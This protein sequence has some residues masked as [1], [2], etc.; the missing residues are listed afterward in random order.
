M[1]D[2]LPA[3]ARLYPPDRL[4]TRAAS[5]ASYESDGLTAFRTRPLAVV[6]AESNHDV[7]ETVRLC[8]AAGVPFVARGSG[9]SLSGGSVPIAD[10]VV[11][12]LNRMNRVLRLDPVD[13]VAVVQPGVINL[14]IS[15]AA[16]PHG[17]YYAP[18]PSS[19]SVC[20]I[21][22]N[23]AFNS[24]GAH[25]FRHGMTAN[26]VLGLEVVLPDGEVVRL[27]GDS[28]EDAGPDLTGL[29]VG[30][31][32][33]FGVALEITVRLIPRPEAY[34]TVLASYASLQAAGDAVTRI[35]AAGLLPGAMEIMD[36]LAIE[37]AEAA[38]HAGYPREAAAV[39]LVELEGEQAQA[40]AELARLRAV[41]DQSA[42]T[43]I[44]V[45]QNADERALLWK[46]RKCAFSAVGRLS[47]DFIVQ[48]GVVP[49]T[50][51]GDALV[52]IE[53]LSAQHGLRVANV[54]HAGDGNLH[55]LILY[56]GREPGALD[57]AEALATDILRL[58]IRLGGSITGEHGVGLEKRAFLPEMYSPDDMAFMQRLRHAVDGRALA[59]RGKMLQVPA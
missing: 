8:H 3:L 22:G 21:G 14:D 11:I 30:S 2:V 38:V 43:H 24:G 17:L 56:D 53:H 37:A 10:G 6:L 29:F 41:L 19:Q 26:H 5:L 4:L 48:D 55:P 18:D 32:G 34:R 50:R 49:R 33:L 45:A 1:A 46:G 9:T 44:R 7:I 51:L 40:D 35:I 42:P 15:A 28:V 27:G 39:L 12:A 52:A 20:T 23:V 58:C 31:E 57:R 59:N 54:F 16:E 13:R 25:C 47:P 36:R